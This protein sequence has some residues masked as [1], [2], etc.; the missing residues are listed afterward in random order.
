M[1]ARKKKAPAVPL[2]KRI[3]RVIGKIAGLL[4][5]LRLAFMVFQGSI[6]RLRIAELPLA[7]LPNSFKGTK[8]LYLSDLH[9]NSLNSID[10]VNALIDELMLLDPDLLLLGGDYTSFDPLMRRPD[11]QP[12]RL[13]GGNRAE[14]SFFPPSV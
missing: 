2:Y 3:L 6:V 4:A 14:R 8:I 10:R 1:A 7:D 11:R 5:A 13:C 12:E 9:I